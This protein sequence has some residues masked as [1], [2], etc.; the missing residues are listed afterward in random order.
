[1]EEFS[2]L[3][4]KDL[5]DKIVHALEVQAV[6]AMRRNGTDGDNLVAA[7]TNPGLMRALTVG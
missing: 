6:G 7:Y 1:V 5:V 2:N 4:G 3:I